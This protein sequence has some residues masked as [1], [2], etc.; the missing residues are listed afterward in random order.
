MDININSS[1]NNIITYTHKFNSIW[2]A[3]GIIIFNNDLTKTIIVKTPLGNIGF[4]KGGRE[5]NERLHQTAY[6]EVKEETSLKSFQYEHD[7]TIIGEKKGNPNK[8]P[9]TIYYFIAKIKDKETENIKLK[10]SIPN[11]LSFVNWVPIEEASNM[12]SNRRKEILLKAHNYITQKYNDHIIENIDNNII[13][14]SIIENIDNI[15]IDNIK[16]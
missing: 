15:I 16:L 8:G 5:K 9:F 7:N 2:Y 6:R 13:D 4:P 12:L 1:R 11:E 14:N 3:S 10:C